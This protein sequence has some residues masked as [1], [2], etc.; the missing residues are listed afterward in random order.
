M[1]DKA[2]TFTGGGLKC[3][4]PD[5]DWID[6][7]IESKDYRKWLNAPCP[8]CGSNLLTDADYKAFKAIRVMTKMINF[9]YFFIPK[10]WLKKKLEKKYG[11]EYNPED[12]VHMTVSFDGSGK[13]YFGPVVPIEKDNNN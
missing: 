12:K 6:M 13:P 9:V 8:K 2:L 4:N 3:D 1:D 7:S 11:E 10:K 5:C